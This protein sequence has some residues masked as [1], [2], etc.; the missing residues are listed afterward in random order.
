MDGL[1]LGLDDSYDRGRDSTANASLKNKYG[2]VKDQH[3]HSSRLLRLLSA[4]ENQTSAISNVS[5]HHVN[6]STACQ[7]GR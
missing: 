7:P 1:D 4:A 3:G 2:V 6:V 5:W